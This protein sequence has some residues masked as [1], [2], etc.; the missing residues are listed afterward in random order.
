MP[1]GCKPRG[2]RVHPFAIGAV[3]KAEPPVFATGCSLFIHLLQQALV[4]LFI[5]RVLGVKHVGRAVLFES[6]LQVAFVL[7]SPAEVG[8]RQGIIGVQAQRL[9][10]FRY[11][12]IPVAFFAERMPEVD[13]RIVIAWVQP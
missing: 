11:R 5:G 8:V 3:R 6:P 7:Q 10:Q 4:V 12:S 1:R 2:S 9:T 13:V